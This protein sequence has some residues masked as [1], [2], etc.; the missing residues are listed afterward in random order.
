[1][2]WILWLSAFVVGNPPSMTENPLAAF[3]SYE[4]CILALRAES[5]VNGY[6]VI[7]RTKTASWSKKNPDGTFNTLISLRCLPLGQDPRQ[8][9]SQG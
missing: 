2:A 5:K 3:P 1:V 4:E 8:I 6:E 9:R 7:E